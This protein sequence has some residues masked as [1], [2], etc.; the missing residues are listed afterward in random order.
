MVEL[1]S[2]KD[3]PDEK[4]GLSLLSGRERAKDESGSIAEDLLC[5]KRR[6]FQERRPLL[7]K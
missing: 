1:T 4:L 6:V 3:S 5:E 2:I 7:L